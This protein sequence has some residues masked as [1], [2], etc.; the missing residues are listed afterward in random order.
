MA[1]VAEQHV[2]KSGKAQ[3]GIF[4]SATSFSGKLASGVGHFVA[5][6]GLDLIAFPLE[7]SPSEV[8]AEAIRNLGLLNVSGVLI[9]LVAIWV[10]RYYRIDRNTQQETQRELEATG[11]ASSPASG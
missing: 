3:Q 7:L 10:F 9:T 1:D 6:V 5:G 11:S 4:F 8:S 2:L